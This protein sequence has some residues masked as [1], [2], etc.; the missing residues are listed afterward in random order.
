[1][2]I[3]ANEPVRDAARFVRDVIAPVASLDDLGL[4]MRETPGGE[5][6]IESRAGF[7]TKD[8][9]AEVERIAARDGR[10]VTPVLTY[11]ANTIRIGNREIP[12]STVTAFGKGVGIFSELRSRRRGLDHGRFGKDCRRFAETAS[13]TNRGQGEPGNSFDSVR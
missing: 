11:V 9:E 5:T 1:M 4:R 2:L 7:L 13:P 8:L 10:T 6:S 3:A 12:Y